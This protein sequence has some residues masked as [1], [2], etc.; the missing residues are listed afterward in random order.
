[1]LYLVT[2]H[3]APNSEAGVHGY[4]V[5]KLLQ[6]ALTFIHLHIHYI[7]THKESEF[8]TFLTSHNC[9]NLSY[10]VYKNEPSHSLCNRNAAQGDSN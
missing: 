2:L 3:K 4:L 10:K 6:N 5:I 8:P 1:M 7:Q 9:K